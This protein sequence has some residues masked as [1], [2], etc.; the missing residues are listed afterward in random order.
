M[1]S[2]NSSSILIGRSPRLFEVG[3][4]K[5]LF[6]KAQDLK[7]I[8][9]RQF[10]SESSSEN[11]EDTLMIIHGTLKQLETFYNWLPAVLQAVNSRFERRLVKSKDSSCVKISFAIGQ[12]GPWI[13]PLIIS[14][15][16][17]ASSSK[18]T[19]NSP[20]LTSCCKCHDQIESHN[21][22][23]R[24]SQQTNI[25]SL[26]RSKFN[27]P[28][29]KE[30]LASIHINLQEKKALK[31]E[32]QD[33]LR[34]T[35]LNHSASNLQF[36]FGLIVPFQDRPFETLFSGTNIKTNLQPE[37]LP[38]QRLGVEPSTDQASEQPIKDRLPAISNFIVK[39]EGVSWQKHGIKELCNLFTNY[40]NVDVAI[41]GD[42]GTDLFLSYYSRQGAEH[43]VSCLQGADIDGDKLSLLLISKAFLQSYLALQNYS[44][45]TPRKRFSSKGPG[46]PNRVNPLSRT[47]HVTYHHD[48]EDRL[49]TEDAILEVLSQHGTVV[50]IKRESASKKKNMW[51][52]EYIDQK[53]ATRVI[54]KQHNKVILGGTLRISFTK[55]I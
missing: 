21:S 31:R 18:N 7:L 30:S 39:V 4:W 44:S 54:M 52:V 42:N 29:L 43:A 27:L 28:Y 5:N 24:E 8:A 36:K 48:R 14:I 22:L 33:N 40:G 9:K 37:T 50:R 12:D 20:Q 15:K 35:P 53:A 46:L 6:L 55:T 17:P 49:L 25:F 51:F 3:C 23:S 45:F 11:R 10:K 1:V 13:G 41:C 16:R 47:L 26:G 34:S 38:P 2:S 32:W 19:I